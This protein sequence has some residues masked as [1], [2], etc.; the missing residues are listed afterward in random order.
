[1]TTDEFVRNFRVLKDQLLEAYCSSS[2]GTA[3]AERVHGMNLKPEQVKQMRSVLDDALTD[4][5]YTILLGLDGC[6]GIGHAP[7][8]NYRITAEDGSDI[9]AG[10]GEIEALAY[11][12][13]HEQGKDQPSA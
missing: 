6:A 9:S 5:I 10:G 3:V 13:F 8:Q 4:T 2:P 1:M 12:Y 7:Q 11:H